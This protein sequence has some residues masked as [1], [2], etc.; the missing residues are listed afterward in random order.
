MKD[1]LHIIGLGDFFADA[2]KCWVL[3]A[4]KSPRRIELMKLMGISNLYICESGF[5]ENLD[6]EQFASA[7]HYV[8]EN[9]LQKGLNVANHVWFGDQVN[10]HSE[11]NPKEA[12]KKNTQ[13]SNSGDLSRGQPNNAPHCTDATKKQQ[14]KSLY[15][16]YDPMPNVIISCDTIVT[17]KDEIIEK[18]L[19]REH[20]FEILKK[21]SSNVHCVYTA[22][23]IF[24][25]KTKVP[26]TFIEKTD[27]HFDNLHER[28]ILEYLNSSEP[29]DKAGAYSIQEV[30]CQFIKKI[31]GCY[32]N[33]MGLPINKLSRT[34]TQL[35]VEGKISVS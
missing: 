32:Y 11:G 17:L 13:G 2:K 4:S 31:N 12:E 28:D 26:I 9:A 21:L 14:L 24:L 5:E 25:H 30:G 35:C 33:V 16:T 7:E 27:V 1:H 10:T 19:N 18:P 34:L 20:A 23:C 29:Y 15:S 6:K 22:V 8:K 3:L